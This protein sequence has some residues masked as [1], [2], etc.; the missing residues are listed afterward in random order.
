MEGSVTIV[1]RKSNIV[2]QLM[3]GEQ[4]TVRG[5]ATETRAVDVQQ[6]TAWKSGYFY[7]NGE[8]PQSAFAQLSRWYDIE[9]V[10]RGEVP[11]VEFYGKIERN[12]PLG[13]LLK[14]LEK[15]GL[16]FEVVKQGNGYQL[17]IGSE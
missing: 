16:A 12:K 4:A 14:I 5:A 9:L 10:Y 1:N 8:L 7:F 13:S 11:P 15:A 17:I 2:N 3:P 6:Y